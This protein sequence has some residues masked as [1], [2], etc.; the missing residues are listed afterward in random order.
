MRKFWLVVLLL[1]TWSTSQANA[2]NEHR[3]NPHA[4]QTPKK[5]TTKTR[6]RDPEA[7]LGLRFGVPLTSQLHECDS[8]VYGEEAPKAI[9]CYASLTTGKLGYARLQNAPDLGFDYI[10]NVMLVDGSVEDIVLNIH[11]AQASEALK[12]LITRFGKPAIVQSNA[13]HA[14][15]SQTQRVY[16]WNS[17][18][19]TIE[20]S[21]QRETAGMWT[22]SLATRRYLKALRE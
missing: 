11:D 7:F 13:P 19:I 3:R 2:G 1:G 18:E 22:V 8:P 5:R 10:A 6:F 21:E 12:L 9:F 15:Y 16:G 14:D 4:E 20:L 17:A